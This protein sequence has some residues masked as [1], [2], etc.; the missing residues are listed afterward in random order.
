VTQQRVDGI[1]GHR[2]FVDGSTPEIRQTQ[3]FEMHGS[4]SVYHR[5][6]KATTDFVSPLFDE[7]SHIT[8]SHT[9]ETDRWMLFDVEADFSE[10]HDLSDVEPERL[11]V[12]Q[13]LWTAEARANNVFPLFDP[14]K[15]YPAH[16]GEYPVP[17]RAT[18]TPSDEP[19][20]VG[21][22]PSMFAGFTMTARVEQGSRANGVLAALG[23]HQGGWVLRLEQ[24]R[25]IFEA[26]QGHASARLEAVSSVGD[27]LCHVDVRMD[28]GQLVLAVDGRDCA[29]DRFDG[30]FLFPGVTTAAGGL[31]VGRHQGLEVSDAYRSPAIFDGRLLD[32]TIV[33]GTPNSTLSL[34]TTMRIGEGAD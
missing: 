5:G 31:W 25:P 16:P 1:D 33:N 8:G 15:N 24:G 28:G 18:Y 12:L 7:R 26:V 34:S 20:A 27:D 23:D 3:Y 11:R 29:T 13:D 32:V 9:Y 2:V 22:L 10:C 14:S 19:V 30:L 4:R 6:W 17:R 21:R